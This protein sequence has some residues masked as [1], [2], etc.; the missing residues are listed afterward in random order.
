MRFSWLRKAGVRGVD[1]V[2]KR[3]R[4]SARAPRVP[5]PRN[6]LSRIATRFTDG[7]LSI[8]GKV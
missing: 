8:Q 3:N 4:I 2:G 6:G 7:D 1:R 5:L